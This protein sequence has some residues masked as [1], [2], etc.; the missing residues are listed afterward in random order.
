MRKAVIILA[1]LW[2][3]FS[4][5]AQ[6]SFI[7]LR[8]DLTQGN[9]SVIVSKIDN[10]IRGTQG[11]FVIYKSDGTTPVVCTNH[12]TWREMRASL[13]SQQTVSDYYEDVDMGRINQ[14][15]VELFAEKVSGYS[16]LSLSGN[17]DNEWTCTFIISKEMVRNANDADLVLRLASINQ[18]ED[19]MNLRIFAYSED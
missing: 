3:V 9:A 6:N 19:R 10:I 11:K 5:F 8:Y 2:C 14:L 17:K 1:L 15:F 12:E 18:L 7:Y 13:L 16:N 4:G